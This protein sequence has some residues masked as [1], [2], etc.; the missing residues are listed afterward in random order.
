MS[1]SEFSSFVDEYIGVLKLE[2][3]LSDNSTG[4]YKSDLKALENFLVE[5]GISDPESVTDKE[6]HSFFVLL[7]ELGLADTSA[8]R[9]HSSLTGFFNYLV[10]S[11]YM[12]SNPMQKVRPPKIKRR[13]PDGLTVSEVNDILNAAN[14]ATPLGLRD[15]AML[16][17]MYA[18]G[19]RVSEVIE[20]KSSGLFLQE[21]MIRV[22]GKGSKE[23]FV[24]IGSSAI[25]ALITYIKEARV[26]LSKLQKSENYVFLNNRGTKISRM[27]VWK[28]VDYYT[29]QA[30]VQKAVHPHTFRHTFATHLIEG[31]ADLRAVQEML[32]HTDISVTQIY[33]H[34]DRN[35]VKAEHEKYHPRGKK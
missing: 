1:V 25:A 16:E 5:C 6:L 17:V 10:L 26:F 8:A 28:I 20:L 24:P 3:N 13:L 23:R 12:T 22:I 29:Q 7:H 19:L 34:V 35:F 14:S 9:Y 21:E 30:G 33:T 4:G 27:G 15:R 18:C 11:G 32:G 31:G 2:R